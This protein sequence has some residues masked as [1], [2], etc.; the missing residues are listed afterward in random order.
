MLKNPLDTVT[1]LLAE[2][3]ST[4][5]TGTVNVRLTF[6][7]GGIRNTEVQVER[8]ALVIEPGAGLGSVSERTADLSHNSE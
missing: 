7:G 2:W 3:R 4:R 6:L 8:P 1:V 5:R